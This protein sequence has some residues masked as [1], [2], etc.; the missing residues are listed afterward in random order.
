MIVEERE[1]FHDDVEEEVS[2][3]E[4]HIS[5]SDF[6]EEDEIEDRLV[7][8][9][10]PRTSPSKK[11]MNVVLTSTLHRDGRICGLEHQN[12]RSSWIM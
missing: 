2:K 3:C 11:G 1:A 5:D 6:E 8:K 4:D 10:S 7:K 12:Q 9:R